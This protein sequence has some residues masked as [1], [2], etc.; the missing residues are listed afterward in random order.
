[1]EIR[2]EELAQR[3]DKYEPRIFELDVLKARLFMLE[4]TVLAQTDANNT[5][6]MRNDGEDLNTRV[7][8]EWHVASQR[9][10]AGS[11]EREMLQGRLMERRANQVSRNNLASP[12]SHVLQKADILL[13]TAGSFV[14]NN[15]GVSGKQ[16]WSTGTGG[17][18]D[19]TAKV[20]SAQDV[21]HS[22]TLEMK[23]MT[24]EIARL[25]QK[26]RGPVGSASSSSSVHP[27]TRPCRQRDP[28]RDCR[29]PAMQ[30]D[31]SRDCREP[32][33]LWKGASMLEQQQQQLQQWRTSVEAELMASRPGL[34]GTDMQW[35]SV[36]GSRGAP[37][38]KGTASSDS[39]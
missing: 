9:R 10:V 20:T 26:P 39:T 19:N 17:F 5:P 31:P 6:L 16:Y 30:R 29:E 25:G 13:S 34:S 22:L 12:K 38:C 33:V 15:C 36:H 3:L 21:C 28:S 7:D 8:P 11:I 23:E 37:C 18:E 24:K 32:A 35:T 1:M 2:C 14:D 4:T 27:L